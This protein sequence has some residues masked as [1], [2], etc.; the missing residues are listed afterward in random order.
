MKGL[1]ELG[2]FGLLNDNGDPASEPCYRCD[3]DGYIIADCFEDTCCCAD[4]ELEHD[5]IP[6]PV[7]TPRRLP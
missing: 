6:C 5:V 2:W 1:I 3:G 7:C 4:P